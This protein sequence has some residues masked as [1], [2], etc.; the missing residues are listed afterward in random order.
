MFKDFVLNH[1][2]ALNETYPY[3]NKKGTCQKPS[4][5]ETLPK[6]AEKTYQYLLNGNE[7]H[8]KNILAAQGP[9]VVAISV[10]NTLMKDSKESVLDL[11][12][13]YKEGIFVDPDC[14]NTCKMINH[15]VLLVGELKQKN[16]KMKKCFL[17]N[18]LTG[19]G[20]EKASGTQYWLLR[21]EAN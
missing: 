2:S 10:P 13:K 17:K 21:W 9:I 18:I 5:G 11:F 8:L 16:E 3:K 20:E 4:D 12:M 19:Y 7:K 6:V 15:A 14:S 1:G